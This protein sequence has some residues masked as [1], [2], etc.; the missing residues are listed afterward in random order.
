MSDGRNNHQE[1]ASNLSDSE[2]ASL[3]AQ[4]F[5]K[6]REQKPQIV[7]P[8]VEEIHPSLRSQV[9]SVEPVSVA[10]RRFKKMYTSLRE[11]V[12]ASLE[13]APLMD[14]KGKENAQ[15]SEA[16]VDEVRKRAFEAMDTKVIRKL[17]L[18]R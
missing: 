2:R 6:V 7:S 14:T 5:G 1:Q 18:I 11:A 4:A 13:S 12:Y 8:V 16:E 17:G 9:R 10:P 15:V 3:L